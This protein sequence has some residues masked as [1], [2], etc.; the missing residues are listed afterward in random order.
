[1]P[2]R[3]IPARLNPTFDAGPVAI[4]D[5][6]R[7]LAAWGQRTDEN[8]RG[9]AVVWIIIG[10]ERKRN[11]RII[12]NETFRACHRSFLFVKID[13]WTFPMRQS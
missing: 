3:T 9:F 8:C 5:E 10:N 4:G 12:Y 13:K 7:T 6:N 2:C 11:A 1:M